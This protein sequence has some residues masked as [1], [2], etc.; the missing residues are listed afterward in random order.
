MATVPYSPSPVDNFMSLAEVTR[1]L[2][3]ELQR[4][5][6]GISQ[7]ESGYQE[8]FNVAPV[9]P[10]EGML[11]YADGTNWNPGNGAGLYEHVGGVWRRI[12]PVLPQASTT[13]SGIVE[14]A[15]V[16][17]AQAGTDTVRAV[18]PE[19]LAAAIADEVK[20]WPIGSVFIAVVSTN[21]NTLLGY[22]TWAVFATG[23]TLVGIDVGQVE[24]DVVEE[25]GGAK[26]H[27]L[28]SAEMPSHSHSI[29][30]PGHAHGERGMATNQP[31]YLNGGEGGVNYG[32]PLTSS[33]TADGA[34]L[35]TDSVT[36]GITAANSG[37]G[38]AH[39]NLQPYIVVYMWKRTA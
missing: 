17:E 32:A 2:Q 10:R 28:T 29:T 4:I 31:F 5:S 39:N 8:V 3:A 24:F 23:R 34:R 15:T 16:A 26:T 12:N 38:G 6:A 27:V 19:G 37:G 13:V 18:T 36:T 20:P 22:G 21:P 35:N 11:A 9:R 33:T 30:D 25:V 1:F 14:L 7:A